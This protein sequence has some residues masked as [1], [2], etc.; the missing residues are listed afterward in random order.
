MSGSFL[1]G[2]NDITLPTFPLNTDGL[3]PHGANALIERLNI[4]NYDDA[5]AIKPLNKKHKYA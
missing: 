5:V 2:L 4:T 1:S 3:D